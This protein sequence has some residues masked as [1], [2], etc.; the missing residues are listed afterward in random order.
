M[1]NALE[2][3]REARNLGSSATLAQVDEEITKHDYAALRASEKVRYAWDVWDKVSPI[4]G[5]AP[6]LILADAPQDGEIYTVAVDGRTVI[7]QK[8]DPE[9]LGFSPMT[10]EQ[11]LG[12]AEKQVDSMVEQV[13]DALVKDQVLR[14]LL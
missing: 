11:A 4:N 8:H 7:L 1:L 6:N 5:I 13:V 3:L 2:V 10:R 12:H 14:A 9:Q